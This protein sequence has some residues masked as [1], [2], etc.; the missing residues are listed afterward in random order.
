MVAILMSTYNG[1]KYVS[2]QIDSLLN[3]TYKDIKIYIRDDGSTDNTV[4]ILE[5]YAEKH[6]NIYLFKEKNIGYCASFMKLLCECPES[7]YYAFCDQDDYWKEEKIAK[8]VEMMNEHDKMPLFY[9]SEVD[10]VNEKLQLIYKTLYTGID[11][12]GSS[13]NTTPAIGCTCVI[14]EKLRKVLI[15]NKIPSNCVSHELYLYRLC[16][17]IDGKVLHDKNSYILYRQHGNNAIG[18][19]KSPLK[20]LK[21]YKKFEKTRNM[22]AKTY[23]EIYSKYISKENLMLLKKIA[24]FY[25]NRVSNKLKVIFDKKFRSKKF[26]SDLKFLYDVIFEKI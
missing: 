2:K 9:Y 6:K 26:K 10:V 3:Q 18:I 20:K 13:F 7:D 23:L 24:D 21:A 15:K 14:N 11:T 22:M 4:S 16:L 19:A 5:K 12:A 17:L 8:A 1:A 25:E